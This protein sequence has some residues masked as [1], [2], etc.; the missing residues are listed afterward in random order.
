MQRSKFD[1][2]SSLI[3]TEDVPTDI[4]Q[5]WRRSAKSVT[6]FSR[7]A[8]RDDL[9]TAAE[10]WQESPLSIAT[11]HEQ[12]NL[13][14][15]VKE[16]QMVAAIADPCGRLLWTCASGYMSK[17]AERLNFT[18]GGH[19]GE[20]EVGTNAVG[21]SLKLKRPVT[22]FSSEHFS[23]FV[24]DWVCY[25]APIIHPKSGECVGILDISTT[26]NKHNPLGQGATMQLAHSIAQSLPVSSFR[27]DLEIHALGQPKIFFQG[28]PL[29]LPLRQ[30]EILCLL[31]LNPDGLGLRQLHS[32]VYGDAPVSTATL[33][34]DVSHLRSCLGGQIG[35]RPYRLTTP[36]WADFV[37]IWDVLNAGNINEAMSLYRG[38]LL[39]KSDSPEIEE[40]RYCVDAIMNRTIGSLNSPE[41]LVKLIGKNTCGSVMERERL[42]ELLS[43]DMD[44]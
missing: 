12:D 32:A 2:G 18:T 22:V 8:P 25:A 40:W 30:L 26:W 31:A 43:G 17:R 3:Q 19:W 15:L 5:S 11:R 33:K 41:K 13:K 35:S 34:A 9:K 37:H 23:P 39:A 4:L 27:A 20:H 38:T 44:R 1:A 42:L 28:E 10:L 6:D 14:H 16:A 7:R 21:L 24:Q 36:F 29:S